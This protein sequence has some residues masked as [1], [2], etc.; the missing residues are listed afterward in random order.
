[1]TRAALAILYALAA[2]G[3]DARFDFTDFS[4]TDR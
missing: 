4:I 2:C 3:D 1:M